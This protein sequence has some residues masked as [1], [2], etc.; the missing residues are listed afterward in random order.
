MT[1]AEAISIFKQFADIYRGTKAEHVA[2]EEAI[3][4]LEDQKDTT[5]RE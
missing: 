1:N 5:P 4:T 2:I 3:Q